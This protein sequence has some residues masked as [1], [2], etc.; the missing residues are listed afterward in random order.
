MYGNNFNTYGFN[1]TTN[2]PNSNPYGYGPVNPFKR[3]K[4]Y[5]TEHY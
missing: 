5:R 1:P 3:I 2:T 4:A